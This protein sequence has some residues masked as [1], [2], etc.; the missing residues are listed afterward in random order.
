MRQKGW[1]LAKSNFPGYRVDRNGSYSKT[2]SIEERRNFR[3]WGARIYRQWNVYENKR[4]RK[5]AIKQYSEY[6]ESVNENIDRKLPC[7]YIPNPTAVWSSILHSFRC[8]D[9]GDLQF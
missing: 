6:E 1:L 5:W 2:K 3:F 9:T 4:T 7:Y 8:T